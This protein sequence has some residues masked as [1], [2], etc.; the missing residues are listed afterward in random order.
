MPH[1]LR[2][3]ATDFFLIFCSNSRDSQCVCQCEI[4]WGGG[5]K[6]VTDTK[7]CEAHQLWMRCWRQCWS[8]G[9]LLP[10]APPHRCK[11]RSLWTWGRWCPGWWSPGRCRGPSGWWPYALNSAGH[12]RSSASWMSAPP[13][14]SPPPKMV[15][16]LFLLLCIEEWHY[17]FHIYVFLQL[18]L[19]RYLDFTSNLDVVIIVVGV[20]S[21]PEPAF[22]QSC[23]KGNPI[24]SEQGLLFRTKCV[25][26]FFF[27]ISVTCCNN[28]PRDVH[29]RL[30][31]LL[32]YWCD[33]WCVIPK[34][35][36]YG[37]FK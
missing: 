29:S 30:W 21:D 18:Y 28:K 1:N 12:A 31:L 23:E 10:S 33:S 14:G 8:P 26:F 3:T 37:F 7:G 36:V 15:I 19:T 35:A 20:R 6:C 22:F 16:I 25:F 5:C 32:L 24:W 4:C 34:T 9:C 17:Y 2:N 13:V 27:W 11:C